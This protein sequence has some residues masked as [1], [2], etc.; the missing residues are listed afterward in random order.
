MQFDVESRHGIVFF[1]LRRRLAT[2]HHRLH[3][4]RIDS[5]LIDNRGIKAMLFFY[6]QG[7]LPRLLFEPLPGVVIQLREGQQP[8]RLP[9]VEIGDQLCMRCIMTMRGEQ[10]QGK[11]RRAYMSPFERSR[12]TD[13]G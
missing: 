1:V 5:I 7:L 8:R 3:Q 2:A 11:I 12:R 10:E 4:C 9:S 6:Y 13:A